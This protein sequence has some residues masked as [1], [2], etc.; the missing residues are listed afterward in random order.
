MLLLVGSYIH[1]WIFGQMTNI[2]HMINIVGQL[3]DNVIP[4]TNYFCQLCSWS[5]LL[6]ISVNLQKSVWWKKGV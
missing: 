1:P 4:L 5:T 3:T 2:T 6:K